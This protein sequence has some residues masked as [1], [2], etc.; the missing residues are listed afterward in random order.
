MVSIADQFLE[1]GRDQSYGFRVVESHATGEAT[2]GYRTKLRY[3]ELV[4]L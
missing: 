2:L 4:E 3:H 1:V